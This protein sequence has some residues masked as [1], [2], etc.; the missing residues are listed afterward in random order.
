MA[1]LPLHKFLIYATSRAIRCPR[2]PITYYYCHDCQVRFSASLKECP[3]CGGK[4]GESPESKK[5]SAIPWWGSCLCIIVG[6][7]T[8]VLSACINLPEL[9]EAAR[10]LI[11]IPMGNLFGMS[12]QR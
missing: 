1:T 10:I 9:G 3:Q 5:E 2:T 6:I 7:I 11:Y 12:L 4:V 8:W